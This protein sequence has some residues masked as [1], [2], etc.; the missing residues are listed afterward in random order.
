MPVVIAVLMIVLGAA[1]VFI[2][3]SGSQDKVW[4]MLTGKAVTGSSAAKA[5][6]K[7]TVA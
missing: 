7:G 3:V 1:L 5:A 2:G 4:R 6:P